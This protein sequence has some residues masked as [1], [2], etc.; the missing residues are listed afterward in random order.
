MRTNESSRHRLWLR[1]DH[2]RGFCVLF[3]IALTILV[4]IFGVEG[5]AL[6]AH[7]QEQH[8][9]ARASYSLQRGPMQFDGGLDAYGIRHGGPI[10]MS[11][12]G[13]SV[14]RGWYVTS[15]K[16][17]YPA[18]AARLIAKQHHHNVDW[19][20][21]AL[22]GATVDR[23]LKWTFPTSQ[24]LIVVHV[25]S[26]DFAHGTPLSTYRIDFMELLQKLRTGS[27]KA[28]LVCLG[29]WGSV[30]AA[31]R[32]GQASYSFDQ[33]VQRSCHAFSGTYV[34]INQIF[35]MTGT[36]GPI[37]HRSLVGLARDGFHPNN[38]G[39]ALIAQAVVAGVNGRPPT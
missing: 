33:I 27:P 37:G 7:A 38:H 30:G 19:T 28:G 17:S 22:P 2:P 10:R 36:R 8:D 1:I 32:W 13:A 6:G 14:T 18:A 9:H 20:V 5:F 39:D 29:D 16:Q 3:G 26:N 24:D 11:V 21:T 34:P 12:I 15:L 31:N 35:A 23:V 4:L 25:V